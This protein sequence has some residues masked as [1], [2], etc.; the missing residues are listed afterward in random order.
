MAPSKSLN[1]KKIQHKK[2]QVV[3]YLHKLYHD[4]VF[5]TTLL[6][7]METQFVNQFDSYLFSGDR[8]D[9]WG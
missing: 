7:G 6:F 3:S 5:Q 4:F 1:I 2:I 8:I 9:A